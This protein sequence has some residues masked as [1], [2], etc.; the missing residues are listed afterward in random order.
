MPTLKI[1]KALKV[2]EVNLQCKL[3]PAK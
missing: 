3:E 2:M 1:S